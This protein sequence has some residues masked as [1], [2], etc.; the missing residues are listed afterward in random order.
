MS[1]FLRLSLAL[2]FIVNI[3]S[4]YAA[5]SLNGKVTSQDVIWEDVTVSGGDLVPSEWGTPPLLRSINTWSPSTYAVKPSSKFVFNGSGG[6]TSEIAIDFLGVQYNSIGADYEASSS[7]LGVAK[8][9]EQRVNSPVIT[10]KGQNCS[11][12]Y[13]FT[14]LEAISPFVFF[15]P[16]F[17]LDSSAIIDSFDNLNA[18]TYR[19]TIPFVI[20][21]YYV[22]AGIWSYRDISD[23]L[24]INVNYEPNHI[25]PFDMCGSS[26]DSLQLNPLY[27][28]EIPRTIDGRAECTTS[29]EGYFSDGIVMRLF[30]QDYSLIHEKDQSYKIPYSII[31]HG[32]TDSK[33]VEDGVLK[34]SDNATYIGKG[35]A[36]T[37]LTFTLDFEY[38]V[39]GNDV[40]SG[41]YSD[42]ITILF[43]PAI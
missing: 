13:Q 29:V 2:L 20:R 27:N 4:V 38:S 37:S 40:I 10:L 26:S 23:Y 14:S 30:D 3:E 35:K 9:V 18:G 34:L 7:T 21:Y 11:S 19:T 33:V 1:K 8:C 43:E 22:S 28:K 15:R 25:K 42:T 24:T 17:N 36:S 41:S 12:S 32:C 31:C 39:S 16:V 6:S 5:F